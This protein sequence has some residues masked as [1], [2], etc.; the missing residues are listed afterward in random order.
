MAKAW[1]RSFTAEIC[2]KIRDNSNASLLNGVAHERGLQN[3]ESDIRIRPIIQI[4][5]FMISKG[6][7]YDNEIWQSSGAVMTQDEENTVFNVLRFT[8]LLSVI[9]QS[10]DYD[11]WL[12]GDLKKMFFRLCLH[13]LIR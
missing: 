10:W 7:L 3:G 11:F 8:L 13:L 4:S 9:I 12:S 6:V 1:I 2:D 5:V